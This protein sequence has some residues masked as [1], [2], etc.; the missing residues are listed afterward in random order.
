MLVQSQKAKIFQVGNV[1]SGIL[2]LATY[3]IIQGSF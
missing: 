1:F 3:N 2:R